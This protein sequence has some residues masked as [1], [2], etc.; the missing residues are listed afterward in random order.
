ME[1][2]RKFGDELERKWARSHYDH[3]VFADLATDALTRTLPSDHL[4][5][6]DVIRWVH[7]TANLPPQDHLKD[8]FGEPPLCVYAGSEFYIEVLFWLEG[9]TSIHEHS[10]SGAFHVL[11]G[12]SIQAEYDFHERRKYSDYV[13]TGDLVRKAATHLHKGDVTTIYT[14]RPTIHSVFHLDRPTTSVV[15]RTYSGSTRAPQHAYFRSGLAAD[16]ESIT[17][18]TKKRILTLRLLKRSDNPAFE[19]MAALF[20]RTADALSTCQFVAEMERDLPLSDLAALLGPHVDA[21]LTRTLLATAR[22]W[23][24]DR[25]V[26]P[27]VHASRDAD[28]THFLG[29]LL[30]IGDR[31]GILKLLGERYPG[32]D[33]AKLLVDWT[34]SLDIHDGDVAPA[35]DETTRLVLRHVLE[36]R[37]GGA[38]LERLADDFD[39]EDVRA[40][41]PD[42][43]ELEGAIRRS[44]MFGPL[45]PRAGQTSGLVS[46]SI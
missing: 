26:R 27:L 31:D 9:H 1:F 21:D 8:A 16:L 28:R 19:E 44:F 30:T 42:L 7:E 45:C 3:A 43:Q 25:W 40:L 32:R 37:S 13:A 39:A 11:E 46:S 29:L 18:K 10:F 24:R 36:G 34:T 17:S 5:P 35:L 14:G 41:A 15:V 38:L 2:F 22:T 20:L 4:S 23:K 12:S 33:V 6:M